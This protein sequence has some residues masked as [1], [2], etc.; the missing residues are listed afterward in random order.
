[1]YRATFEFG[2]YN[3]SQSQKD[4]SLSMRATMYGCDFLYR[5]DM[6]FLLAYGDQVPRFYDAGL[7]YKTPNDPCGGDVWQDIPTLLGRKFGDCKDLACFRAAE[8]VVKDKIQARPYVK[9]KFFADGF[10]LYHVV[11]LLPNGEFEDPS[12]ALGMPV[13]QGV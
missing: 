12:I 4:A 11:V 3:G 2:I 8:L 6:D 1:M 7:R 9:R 5:C 13:S 10:A